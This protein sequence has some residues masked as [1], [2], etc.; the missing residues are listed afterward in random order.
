MSVF[1]IRVD[2]ILERPI[3]SFREISP[4]PQE[5]ELLTT[6]PQEYNIMFYVEGKL[7]CYYPSSLATALNDLLWEWDRAKSCKSHEV[8]LSGY[9][10]LDIVF[11]D[12]I[13][14]IH[15]PLDRR[16]VDNASVPLVSIESSF[17]Q[18]EVRGC[19]NAVLLEAQRKLQR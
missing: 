5:W 7:Y 12:K 9:T 4:T 15:D 17:Y 10:V 13:V 14:D 8:T 11:H 1:S 2:P 18:S 19:L 3:T 6:L 16:M